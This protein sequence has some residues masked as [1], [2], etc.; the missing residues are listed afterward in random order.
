LG[1]AAACADDGHAGPGDTSSGGGA[2]TSSDA[3]T[4]TAAGSS[5]ETS[6]VADTTTSDATSSGP[7]DSTGDP[8]TTSEDDSTTDTDGGGSGLYPPAPYDCDAGVPGPPFEWVVV[9]GVTSTED[10]AFDTEGWLVASDDAQSLLRFR[11][12]GTF[13]LFSPGAG[14]S[15]G[16]DVL[17][18]G[19][20]VFTNP[21]TGEVQRVAADSGVVSLYTSAGVSVSGVDVAV[22]GTLALGDLNGYVDVYDAGSDE[23]TDWGRVALQLYGTA[24]SVDESRIYFASYSSSEPY[25]YA[26]ER[27]DDGTWPEPEIWTT[28]SSATLLAGMATDAC[29]N[30]YAMDAINCALW[31]FDTD[32]NEELLLDLPL[33]GGY[34]PALAFGRGLGDWDAYKLYISTYEE[35]VEVDIGVP[36][37]PR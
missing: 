27:T 7:A 36:G 5:A 25:I 6:G 22:D 28:Y 14:E 16:I 18:G 12:D 34:C 13:E 37:R 8:T 30:L 17:Q 1:S 23:L 31:R 33:P 4:T 32:G 26:T 9:E 21:D 19:D 2:S 29:D 15:R 20:I 24:F 35:V 10:I 3:P 11:P